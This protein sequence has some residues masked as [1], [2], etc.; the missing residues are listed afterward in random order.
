L[1][2]FAR[3]FIQ[4]FSSGGYGLYISYGLIHWLH[5]NPSLF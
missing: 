3:T 5:L 4:L 1:W 2:S